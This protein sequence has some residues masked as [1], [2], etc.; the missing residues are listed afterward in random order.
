MQKRFLFIVAHTLFFVVRSMDNPVDPAV[1][2]MHTGIAKLEVD[3]VKHALAQGADV[4]AVDERGDTFLHHIVYRAERCNEQQQQELVIPIMQV[5][6]D[7]GALVNAVNSIGV[8]PLHAAVYQDAKYII[9]CLRK[10]GADDTIKDNQGRG[11]LDI[12]LHGWKCR[13]LLTA[14]SIEEMQ[15]LLE[16]GANPDGARNRQGFALH[17]AVQKLDWEKVQLLLY[18]GANANAQAAGG[19]T[20]LHHL[21]EVT[22][23]YCEQEGEVFDLAQLLVEYAADVDAVDVFGNA[24]LHFAAEKMLGN[25]LIFLLLHNARLVVKN[26]AGQTPLHCLFQN[27]MLNKNQRGF[28]QNILLIAARNQIKAIVPQEYS[29]DE[30]VAIFLETIRASVGTGDASGRTLMQLSNSNSISSLVD[31]CLIT[32]NFYDDAVTFCAGLRQDHVHDVAFKSRK[33]QKLK[34]LRKSR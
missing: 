10:Q 15:Q 30:L 32:E 27:N 3:R 4:W 20:P 7:A 33:D 19:K 13:R 2:E 23:L 1:L 22:S 25:W 26:K 34:P 12:S 8:V 11:L 21:V 17:H 31:P 9:D 28:V 5:L 14:A 6:L 18:H 29:F 16:E 24:A